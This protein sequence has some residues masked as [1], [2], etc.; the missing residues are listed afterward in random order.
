MGE[1]DEEKYIMPKRHSLDSKI[2]ITDSITHTK[3]DIKQITRIHPLNRVR[4]VCITFTSHSLFYV[5]SI[6][7]FQTL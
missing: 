2:S 3:N 1:M 7:F 6:C 4:N 5:Q